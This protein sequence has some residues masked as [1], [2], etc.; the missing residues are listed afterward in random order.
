[1]KKPFILWSTILILSLIVSG[2]TMRSM[3]LQGVP[4]FQSLAL[5]GG[6][7]FIAVLIYAS[8]G[9]LSL[10][11]KNPRTQASRAALAG[12]AL[13]FFT[14][15]YEYLSASAVS[16]LSN[17]DLPIMLALAPLFGMK[18]DKKIRLL[19][20]ASILC[21]VAYVAH[22]GQHQDLL[23]GLVTLG[24]G[25][26]LL[27][28]G[29]LY[30]KKSMGEENSSVTIMVPSL[31]IVLYGLVFSQFSSEVMAPTTTSL[32]IEAALSGLSM[33]GA[34]IATMKLYSLTNIA[35]A[36]FPTLLSSV[37]IQPL[38]LFFLDA[39]LEAPYLLSSTAFVVCIYF[40]M[41]LQKKLP[42]LQ[43]D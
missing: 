22:L 42:E 17:V 3:A 14:L 18:L 36:E 41:S 9:R 31:A 28:L 30:I 2:L 19:S 8:L 4:Y 21:L 25:S 35:T 13:G 10:V 23:W 20:L 16:V 33:F 32:L 24:S 37:L 39:P 29:Y 6:F 27:C 26:F 40:I 12:L 1:M 34:Y 38:E 5:R 11:P 43:N 15:S 7:S